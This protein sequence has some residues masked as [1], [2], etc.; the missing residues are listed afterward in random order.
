MHRTPLL[1]FC[2]AALLSLAAAVPALAHEVVLNDGTK[3]EGKVLRKDE[4]EV[5]I[6]TT[7]DGMKTLKRADVKSVNENVPPLRDQLKYRASTAKNVEER[8][9]LYTWAKRRGFVEELGYILEAIVDLKPDD[10]KA[11]KLL[12]HKK[13]DGAWMTPEDEKKHL[14]EKFAAE[15]RAKGLVLYEGAWVT[16]EE[17]DAREKG[18]LKD[19]DDWVTEEEWHKRRG[20]KLVGGKWIK[21]GFAEGKLLG[22]KVLRESRVK[23][24]YHWGP[25]FDAIAEVNPEVTKR[26]LK[27]CEKAYSKMRSTLRPTEEDYPD[28][29]EERIRLALMKKLPGFV[30]FSKWFDKTYD[31]DSLVPGFVRAIQ[32]QHSWWWVQDHRWTAN[33]Q[34]PNTEKTYVSNVVH[35]AGLIMLTR[36]KANYAFPSVWLREGFAYFLEMETL[37]YSQSFSL[38]RGGSAGAGVK[39]P[40]WADSE[41]WRAALRKTVTEGLDPPLRRM[42][43]MGVD[44]VG[45]EELVKSWSIVEFLTRWDAKKFKA[46]IDQSKERGTSEQDALKAA[47]GV[48]Y[49]QCDTKWRAYVTNGF[50][51]P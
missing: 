34:F 2:L 42:A 49:K 32:R 45:Y 13:V 30:R 7:F 36:Y 16:P 46:F 39:G 10:R 43:K 23:V 19:G 1:S 26:I 33:Y 17:R 41:Q 40:A 6:E 15:Q 8:W 48:T 14:A 4:K 11:R 47:F 35:N 51:V 21:V 38:G 37:G 20:E 29:V 5:V 18:L 31:A 50:K 27:A 3:L 9:D 12:G 24:A 22:A 25:H 44:R 28:V